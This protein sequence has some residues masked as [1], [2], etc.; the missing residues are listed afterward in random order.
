LIILSHEPGLDALRCSI[1]PDNAIKQAGQSI[2][3][4]FEKE[5]HEVNIPGI[6]TYQ[7]KFSKHDLNWLA[8]ACQ[9]QSTFFTK[10]NATHWK[11]NNEAKPYATFKEFEQE[12]HLCA[13]GYNYNF[14]PLV[15]KDKVECAL[16]LVIAAR[17]IDNFILICRSDDAYNTGY[18][19]YGCDR[20]WWRRS[21]SL[22]IEVYRVGEHL[23]G[24]IGHQ[25]GAFSSAIVGADW[26]NA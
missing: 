23:M 9:L 13:I 19:Q 6:R 22:H 4:D 3:Q 15:V 26:L 18:F 7:A 25:E 8:Q 11:D 12:A 24:C 1:L 5:S 20:I 14:K 17:N 2:W 21:C 16:G 10:L